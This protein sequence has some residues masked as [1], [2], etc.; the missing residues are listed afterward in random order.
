MAVPKRKK[1]KMKTR[2]QRASNRYEGVQANN[3]TACGKPALPHRVC[4]SC[5]IYSGKQI[6][7]IEN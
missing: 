7:T 1:S 2:Q 5:G 6:I 3:C 4:R